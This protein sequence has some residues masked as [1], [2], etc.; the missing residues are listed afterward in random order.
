[1]HA[2][3]CPTIWD[4]M[5]W[6]P[7]GSSVHEIFQ[8]RV[9]EWGAITFSIGD[10]YSECWT[11]FFSPHSISGFLGLAVVKNMPANAGDAGDLSLIPGSGRPPGEGNGNPLQDSY[12]ENY[13]DRES[14]WA[15]VY[16]FSVR[17]KKVTNTH[18]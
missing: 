6:N 7:P 3:S 4:P 1:M 2:Q 16:G 15:T 17:H 13:V 5:D 14:Q 11:L 10:P 18:L 12:L 9:L 8:T